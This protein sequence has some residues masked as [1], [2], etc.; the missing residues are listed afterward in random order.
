MAVWLS[1]FLHL[2]SPE[3]SA[4]EWSLPQVRSSL[5]KIVRSKTNTM[6]ASIST[7]K[8]MLASGSLSIPC[9]VGE[10]SLVLWDLLALL[11]PP[12]TYT[13]PV[14]GLLF[15]S[16][17]LLYHP[18]FKSHIFLVLLLSLQSWFS[19]LLSLLLPS[20][21]SSIYYHGQ[22]TIFFPCSGPFLMPLGLFSLTYCLS[23]N[24]NLHLSCTSEHS[25]P[26]FIQRWST[27]MPP[28]HLCGDSRSC[29]VAY[30]QHHSQAGL[31]MVILMSRPPKFCMAG[32]E[33]PQ[34]AAP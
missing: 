6:E 32:C 31:Y 1:P 11:D 20:R 34:L 17:W 16:F 25:Y 9:T 7:P 23:Y 22:C 8:R 13:F 15:L 27:S 2:W 24:K 26:H 10:S 3:S 18:S 33:S 19:L 30:A 29:Q 4:Q 21:P 14:Q 5:D 12:V 28:G